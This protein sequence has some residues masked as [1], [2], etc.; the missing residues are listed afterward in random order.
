MRHTFLFDSA[1]WVVHGEYTYSG[2]KPAKVEGEAVITHL[3]KKWMKESTIK[4]LGSNPLE[5]IDA[6]TINP[7]GGKE[8]LTDWTSRNS[9]FGNMTGKY[10]VDGKR[11][12]S[13]YH[14]DDEEFTGTEYFF[15]V[16]KDLYRNLCVLFKKEARYSSWSLE[17]KKV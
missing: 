4:I 17:I 7:L 14:S 13:I 6:C 16:N 9:V 11:I 12:I 2:H 3:E 1:I 8:T 5:I 10:M 15:Y